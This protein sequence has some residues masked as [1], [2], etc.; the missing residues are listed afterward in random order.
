MRR[1][2]LKR[3]AARGISAT[4]MSVMTL[5]QIGTSVCAE[6]MDY[7]APER[8]WKLTQLVVNGD[9][10]TGNTEGW[11]VNLN[12]ADGDSAGT[13]I[14]IDEWASNN[15]TQIFN[16]WN[17]HADA[18]DFCLSQN[19]EKVPAGTYKLAFDADG[20][21]AEPGIVLKVC[22]K[23]V[24]YTTT[25]W[26]AW[27]TYETE[28]FTLTEESDITIGF[29]GSINSGYWGDI[30]NVCL[31]TD[32]ETGTSTEGEHTTV[33]E[34]TSEDDPKNTEGEKTE[35]DKKEDTSVNAEIFVEKVPGCDENFITGVDVSSYI[36]LKNG[37]VKFYNYE[38]E[39]LDDQG[40]FNFLS[41]CG[42]NYVRLRV[43]NNPGDENGNG[44]G[45]GNCDL[46]KAKTIGQWVTNAGMRVLIDFHYSDFWADPGKQTAPKAWAGMG[47]DEKAAALNEYTKVSLKSLLDA[48]VD[49]GMVQVGNETNNGIAGESES[50]G[51]VKLFA[52]G[53]QGVRA[54]SE[55]TGKDI[56]VAIHFTNPESG[57]YSGYAQMLENGGV[58]YDVFASSYYP[59]WHG[60]IDNLNS[61]LSKVAEKYNKKVMV[62]ETS[63][64]YT[65][66]D[67]DGCENTETE[68]DY[69]EG[70]D[71]FNFDVSPQGQADS[72]RAVVNAV[73]SATNGIGV[74]YWEPAWLPVNQDKKDGLSNEEFLAINKGNWE[75]YGTGWA[76]DNA[77]S[78]DEGAR[79]YGGGGAVVENEAW[80][81]FTG[82]PL[83]SAKMYSY[84]RTGAKAELKITGISTE[85]V[86]AE[87]GEEIKLSD[88]VTV[89]YNN[90]TSKEVAVAW[91][92]EELEAA[93]NGGA[94]EYTITGTA[95]VD[96]EQV[97]TTCKLEIKAKNYLV[98]PG[99]E[100][101]KDGWELTSGVETNEIAIKKDSSNTHSGEWCMKFWNETAY[102]FDIKQTITLDKGIY[103]LSAFLEGGDAGEGDEFKLYT[104]LDGEETAENTT[105]NGWQEFTN[106]TISNIVISNDGTQLTIG[107]YT[108]ASA[109]CWGAWDDFALIKTGDVV[110]E[111]IEEPKDDSAKKETTD[112]KDKTGNET[113]ETTGSKGKTGNEA[114]ETTGS[115]DKNGDATTDSKDK[116][117]NTTSD[118]KASNTT[119]IQDNKTP[120]VDI[121]TE[122]TVV[123]VT[124]VK[125]NK[126]KKTLKVGKKYQLKATV[127]PTDAT[128]KNVSWKSSN[129]KVAKV[130]KNGKV[131]AVGK[132]KATITVVTK[133]GKFKAKCKITVK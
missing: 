22:D 121:P 123:K 122:E 41:S 25:G 13:K 1:V 45:G 17:N 94:G 51:M 24:E 37:G 55:E 90:N 107:A 71:T 92:S 130:S 81:D 102:E 42:V 63:Y 48:G 97:E 84:M 111:K 59:Y 26:D 106:P 104:I 120:A 7:A 128:N 28:E 46:E 61:E 117:G 10:E 2:S 73:A 105:L 32:G 58:N 86:T 99:F 119:I 20:A 36:A 16:F 114:T 91:N 4:L 53:A 68:A 124:E 93:K 75:T 30:D 29:E 31:Y 34:K 109:K 129:K 76:T 8:N 77:G 57:R 103:S 125:L 115:K 50:A 47:T 21:E 40:Y 18:E 15:K 69:T 9:F 118:S 3:K 133:D 60:T 126:K 56:L 116:T 112:S 39:E 85:K 44:Y 95:D 131:T 82:H 49:V 88:T 113:T 70:K 78:Y 98:N 35:N 5:A 80:F 72:V 6:E 110:Q 79:K 12:N 19:I 127:N 62:A 100:E 74:F 38:G 67:G 83:A 96:G 52:A 27:S 64:V 54:V 11:E 43:W 87:F 66:E 23:S 89:K 65:L 108:K 101:G 14:K 132:G 33:G